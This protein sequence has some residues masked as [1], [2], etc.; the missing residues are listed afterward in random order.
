MAIG[1]CHGNVAETNRA[2]I[3][4]AVLRE[5]SFGKAIPAVA[6]FVRLGGRD[7][8]DQRERNELNAGGCH[9]V[10]T[11]ELAAR[12]VQSQRELLGAVAEEITAAEQV[13]L[14]EAVIDLRDEAAQIVER[15]GD[16]RVVGSKVAAAVEASRI[17]RGDSRD[18]VRGIVGIEVDDGL[19]DR[20]DRSART[21]DIA[22]GSGDLIERRN[23]GKT[24]YADVLTLAFVV[25]IEERL[26]FH[27][28]AAERSAELVVVE[29]SFR[30]RRWIEIIPSV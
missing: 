28:R 14:V 19:A 7:H 17:V 12:G 3:E 11:G 16:R 4:T 1:E 20:T 23:A 26:V 6:K 25:D 8:G 10:K 27:D 15:G 24:D 18:I 22:L 5:K 29:R 9:G 30:S 2:R 13:G 21:D